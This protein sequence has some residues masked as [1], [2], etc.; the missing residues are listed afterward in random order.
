MGVIAGLST[1]VDTLKRFHLSNVWFLHT[2]I[3]LLAPAGQYRMTF[4]AHKGK[5]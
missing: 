4:M 2:T 5:S 1:I 3:R